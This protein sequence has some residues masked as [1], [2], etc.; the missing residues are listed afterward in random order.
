MLLFSLGLLQQFRTMPLF[1]MYLAVNKL[2]TIRHRHKLTHIHPETRLQGVEFLVAHAE[3][4]NERCCDFEKRSTGRG[5][6]GLVGQIQDVFS[7][8]WQWHAR[9]HKQGPED[10][11][12]D[13]M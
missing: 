4:R 13:E 5:D 2:K 11:P 7:K 10:L 12:R 8:G 9:Q 6:I 3:L 1:R